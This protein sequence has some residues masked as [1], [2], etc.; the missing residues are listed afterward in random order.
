MYYVGMSRSRPKKTRDPVVEDS[1]DSGPVRRATRSTRRYVYLSFCSLV[2]LH[3]TLDDWR[4]ADYCFVHTTCHFILVMFDLYPSLG[5][6]NWWTVQTRK[7]MVQQCSHQA[8]TPF[9]ACHS[10]TISPWD[11]GIL[12]HSGALDDSL[13]WTFESHDGLY[14]FSMMRVFL[15]ELAESRADNN[16]LPWNCL[17]ESVSCSL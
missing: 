9:I 6:A 3:F 13:T 10:V 12:D 11:P 16:C 2:L 5:K 15:I 14:P 8:A 7:V 17:G 1:A 4:T